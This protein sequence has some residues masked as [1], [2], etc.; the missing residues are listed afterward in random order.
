MTPSR[1]AHT[2]QS[3]DHASRT[4]YVRFTLVTL[5]VNLG[6][7]VWGGF[8]RASG[9]GAGCGN[10]WP[11]CN[12]E[13]IP[14][15]PS[16]QTLIELSHR[17][18]SGIALILVVVMAV[19]AWRRFPAGS[20]VRRYALLTLIFMLTEA[21]VGAGLVLFELVADNESMA[22]ALFMAVHLANTFLLLGAMTLTWHVAEGHPEPAW[23]RMF[24]GD[25][26]VYLTAVLGTIVVG[27]SGAVAA[28]GDTL[29]PAGS[30]AEGLAADL[31]PT[32]HLL[33]RLR[34]L[35]PAIAIAIGVLLFVVAHRSSNHPSADQKRWGRLLAVCIFAQL[36]I[37]IINIALLAPIP[38][39]LLH[40]LVADLLWIVLM[41]LV[42]TRMGS[43][44]T[45]TSTIAR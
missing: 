10:N 26:W 12:G 37:G 8:V 20:P 32:S 45:E 11:L 29:Y 44:T 9:S 18:T 16:A 19:L 23:R 14:R 6:V 24:R 39:Q 34:I 28:L 27:T 36:A 3:R 17:L 2:P 5:A 21:G 22:R 31:S 40:L 38:I 25:G 43:S 42:A 4:G 1:D 41:R 30:L 13:V 35:H 33:I 15:A 7:I